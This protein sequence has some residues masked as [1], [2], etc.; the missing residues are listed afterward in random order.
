MCQFTDC[1]EKVDILPIKLMDLNSFR[2]RF[3]DKSEKNFHCP[4]FLKIEKK[5]GGKKKVWVK[6]SEGRKKCGAKNSGGQQK[7]W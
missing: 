7:V 6:K 5:S 4:N 1:L 3:S 2:G